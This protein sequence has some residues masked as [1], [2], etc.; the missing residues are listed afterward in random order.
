MGFV[1][2]G[3]WE[4]SE[5]LVAA[6]WQKGIVVPE[7]DPAMIRKDIC[8]SWMKFSEYGQE[9]TLGW[10]I[11]HIKPVAKSGSDDLSNLQPLWWQNNRRKGDAYPWFG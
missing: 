2:F 9:T 7:Y 11:D 1:R 8:G 10:E 6:V 4:A 5:I 3:F